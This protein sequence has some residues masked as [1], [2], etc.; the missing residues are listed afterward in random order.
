[1]PIFYYFFFKRHFSRI[2]RGGL[3][4]EKSHSGRRQL[5]HVNFVLVKLEINAYF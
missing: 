1:M 4:I 5:S 2:L 3:Q